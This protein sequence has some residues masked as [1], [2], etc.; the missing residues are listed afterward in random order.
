MAMSENI[1]L[2]VVSLK[3]FNHSC[4]VLAKRAASGHDA[5]PLCYDNMDSNPPDQ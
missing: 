3:M 2:L 1:L 4:F 5:M